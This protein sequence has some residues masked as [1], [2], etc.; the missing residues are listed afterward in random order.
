VIFPSYELDCKNTSDS[1]AHRIDLPLPTQLTLGGA[2]PSREHIK[3]VVF[4]CPQ[5]QHVHTYDGVDLKHRVSHADLAHLPPIPVPVRIKTQCAHPGCDADI[6]I[7]TTRNAAEKKY[8]V[9]QRLRHAV[10]HVNCE[11][12]HV[13]RFTEEQACEITDGPLCNPF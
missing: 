4:A 5:C 12:G 2:P 9:L 8:E 7:Y 6:T 3:N 10:F 13:P 11:N 1:N